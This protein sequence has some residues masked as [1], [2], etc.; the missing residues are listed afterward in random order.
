[1]SSCRRLHFGA[2]ALA[3][4]VLFSSALSAQ[5]STRRGEP[6]PAA[7]ISPLVLES[8]DVVR[9]RA[10]TM[11]PPVRTR[12][13]RND[14][15]VPAPKG[16]SV[17]KQTGG[18]GAF[19]QGQL[20]GTSPTTW[21]NFTG[22]VQGDPGAN[23]IPPDT[24]GANGPNHYLAITNANMSAWRKSDKRRVLNVGL[25]PFWNVNRLIG[26][27]RAVYDVHAKR[28][29]VLASTFTGRRIYVAISK[30]S[31]PSGSWFKFSFNVAVG[32]DAGRWSDYPTLGVDKRGIYTAA[33]QVG[34]GA[35]MTIWAIDK[36]PLLASTPRVG[37]IT[38]F[39][40]LRWEGAI[41]PCTTYGDPGREYFVSR[42]SSTSLRIRR[43]NPPLTAPTLT[44]MGFA[45]IPF[46]SSPPN[47]PARGSTRPL[48]TIDW[49]PMNAVYR[50]GSI[51]TAQGVN[52]A[53]RSAVRWYEIRVSPLSTRQVGTISDRL[54][55]YFYGTV[56]VDKNGDVGIGFSGSH[57]GVYASSFVA[58]HRKSDPPGQ[59][60]APIL[61]KAGQAAW[62]RID[63]AGRNRFGDYSHIDVDPVDEIGF[64]TI[65]E[66]IIR[67][68]RWATRITRFGYE[69]VNYGVGLAGRNGVPSL[70]PAARPV[71]NSGVTIRI[72]NS[73][74]STTAGVFLVGASKASL[75]VLGGTVLVTPL[76]VLPM[77]IPAAGANP[78]VPYPN[79]ATLVNVPIYYQ[80][81]ELDARAVQGF[82]FS[83]GLVLRA[84]SK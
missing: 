52:V 50:N 13:V 21:D 37:T 48:S 64:W 38:A 71:I 43:V 51:Y 36:A 82:A 39:R 47:A 65:Q 75:A 74:G 30:T 2:V 56:A 6:I 33:F 63:R 57:A 35:R 70:R 32:S 27:P 67:T 69:A 8:M 4:P 16:A 58:A 41:Q 60:S 17:A 55:S 62:N 73:A 78:V 28:F 84:G 54:W 14:Q 40:S 12:G 66:F 15:I 19:V 24:C 53:G 46:H 72:G 34:R 68:N 25:R 22:T 29:V 18:G 3:V 61:T 44:E 9:A 5:T 1:M 7:E 59:T 11:A 23:L 26:D 77:S 31:D 81:I 42:R 45:S 80:A 10:R 76:V 49:R 20:G 83:R 79:D